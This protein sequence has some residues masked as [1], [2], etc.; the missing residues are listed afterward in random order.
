MAIKDVTDQIIK[1]FCGIS[2][3]NSDALLAG[4]KAAAQSLIIS[5]TGLSDIEINE[6]EDLTTAYLVLINDMY[7]SRDYTTAN[8][9]LNPLVS[10]ILSL[11]SSNLVG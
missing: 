2:D 11:H 3:D 1:D 4:F 5:Y 10:T 8:D 9:R 7:N 6:Y